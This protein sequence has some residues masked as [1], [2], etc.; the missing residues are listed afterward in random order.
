MDELPFHGSSFFNLVEEIEDYAILF[1][2]TQGV[3]ESWNKGVEKIKGYPASEI[4]GQNFRVFYTAEDQANRLPETLIRQAAETGRARHEGWRVRKDSS[5]FWGN[6]TL[7]A[8]RDDKKKLVGFMKITRDLTDAMLA[9]KTAAAEKDNE[10]LQA[11][12]KE[13][14]HFT[15]IASHDLQEPLNSITSLARVL[16]ETYASALD[17]K[18]QQCIRYILESSLRMSTRIRGLLDYSRLGKTREAHAVNCMQIAD[19]TVSDLSQRLIKSSSS[20]H[21]GKLPVLVAYE[22]E[23]KILFLNLLSNAVKFRR[24]DI[25]PEIY[26]TAERKDQCWQFSVR[27]NGIGIEPGQEERIFQIFQRLNSSRDYEG[28]GIGLSLCHKAVEL[29]GG[30]IWVEQVPD[31]GCNFI[32]TIPDKSAHEKT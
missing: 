16:N 17:E 4:I 26:L 15:Y 12:N 30:K 31:G 11:K 28:D 22:S 3:I 9:Q 7:S 5:L 14:E 8:L 19:E 1:L 29:H 24:K 23:L 20:V 32:F 21:I 10:Y 25:K 27:D 6:I 2:N 13:L 18:G